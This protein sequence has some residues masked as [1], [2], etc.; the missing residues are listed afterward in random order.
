MPILLLL[1]SLSTFVFADAN[2]IHQAG[3]LEIPLTEQDKEILKIGYISS[4]DEVLGGLLGIYPGFGIG[5]IVQGRWKQKG[6]I[7]TVGEIASLV[8]LTMG[9]AGCIEDEFEDDSF[10]DNND[11]CSSENNFLLAAGTI[12][13]VGFKIWEIVDVWTAPSSHNYRYQELKIRIERQM[14]EP[15]KSSLYLIPLMSPRSGPGLSLVL[16]F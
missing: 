13:F 8:A 10:E 16:T 7:F 1:L 14:N 6:W 11:S 9:I 5:H 2:L 12:G 15:V 3:K 4:S